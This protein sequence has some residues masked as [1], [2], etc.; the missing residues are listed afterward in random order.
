M[1]G[2]LVYR[3]LAI[4]MV[5]SACR[6]VPGHVG[7]LARKFDAEV[8]SAFGEAFNNLVIHSY[9]AEPG[10]IEIEIEIGSGGITIRMLDYGKSYDLHRVPEPDLASLPESGL[11]IYIM[12]ACMDDVTYMSGRPNVLTMTKSLSADNQSGLPR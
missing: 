6:L 11:G 4:R 2:L 7:A 5:A 9:G 3:D 1:P 10:E 8:I 12:R